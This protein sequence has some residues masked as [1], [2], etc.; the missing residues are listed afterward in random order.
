MVLKE[1]ILPEQEIEKA[2]GNAKKA[3]FSSIHIPSTN[4]NSITNMH[5]AWNGLAVINLVTVLHT[6]SIQDKIVT[7]QVQEVDSQDM[8]KGVYAETV[9]ATAHV[10]A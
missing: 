4:V 8:L 9:S 10:I 6:Y 1:R 2:R 7:V 5:K 3:L